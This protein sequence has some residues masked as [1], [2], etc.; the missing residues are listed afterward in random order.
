MERILKLHDTAWRQT[1][2]RNTNQR[3]I[4]QNKLLYYHEMIEIATELG[5]T[6]NNL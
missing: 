6:V 1:L 5:Y 2:R 4:Q 3:N